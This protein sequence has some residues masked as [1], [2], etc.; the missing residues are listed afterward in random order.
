MT[1]QTADERVFSAIYQAVQDHRLT[2]GVK[3]REVEMAELFKVSRNSVRSAFLRLSHKGLLALAPNRG[4]SVAQPTLKECREILAARRAIEGAVVESLAA[5]ASAA[6]IRSL[7]AH[8]KAQKAAFV[9]G[10][11]ATGHRLAIEFHRLL[12]ELSGNRLLR[13]YVDD[14]LGR[15]PLIVLSQGGQRHSGEATHAGHIELVEAIAK[16]DVEGARRLLDEH[17]RDLEVELKLTAVPVESTLAQIF[18]L[19]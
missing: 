7:R 11:A 12:A 3:L 15:M 5:S 4:A 17:L 18:G 6:A 1:D 10:D 9:A 13:G 8:V 2:P 14:L 19:A 16:H